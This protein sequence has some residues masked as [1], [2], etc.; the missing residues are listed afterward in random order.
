MTHCLFASDLHGHAERYEK[1]WRATSRIRPRRSFSAATCCP[2]E[3]ADWTSL[4]PDHRDFVN[5]FLAAG[6]ESVRRRTRPALPPGLPHPG[7]RRRPVRGGR[8]PRR[9]R[10]AA[11]WSYVHDRSA[12]LSNYRGLRLRLRPAAPLQA[13]GLGALRRLALRGSGL[14]LSGGGPALVRR[15]RER[16]PLLHHRRRISRRSPATG[17]LEHAVFLFHTPALRDEPRPR[18]QRRQDDRPRPAGPARR[19]HRDAALHRGA[20]AARVPCTATS[21]NPRA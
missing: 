4:A 11:L 7:Q 2:R 16:D 20:P 15:A 17:P 10:P 9:R 5:D 1:L 3:M 12:A 14:R 8:D 6:F 19:E 18:G 21:T 13:Q